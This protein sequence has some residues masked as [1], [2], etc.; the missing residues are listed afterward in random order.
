[1]NDGAGCVCVLRDVTRLRETEQGR[2]TVLRRLGHELRTPLAALQAVV[3]NLLDDAPPGQAPALAVVEAETARLA[4]LGEELL[5][6]ARGPA[7]ARLDLRPLDLSAL[8]AAACALFGTRAERLGVH[9]ALG[10]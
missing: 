6:V 9:L 5:A 8:A 1:S 7:G 2:S 3:G 10:N 4:R